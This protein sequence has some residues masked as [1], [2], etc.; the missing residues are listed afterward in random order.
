MISLRSRSSV[1]AEPVRLRFSSSG[2]TLIFGLT[3]A[4][5]LLM[6]FPGQILQRRLE[7]S[8]ASDSLTI[9]YLMAWLRA[10]PDDQH[11]RLQLALHQHETGQVFR[12]WTTLQ[13]V[14]ASPAL[15]EHDRYRAELLHLNLLEKL[16]WAE[17]ADSAIFMRR[18]KE[19]IEQL[20]I[21]SR[22]PRFDDRLEH[23]AA[24]A[25]AMGEIHLARN[26]YLRLITSDRPRN[27]NW[28]RQIAVLALAD[29]QP[30]MAGRILLLGLD[31][32]PTPEQRRILFLE[33]MR[34]FQA[35]NRLEEALNAARLRLGSLADDPVTLEA[36]ARLALAA[37][38]PDIAE[39]YVSLLLKQRIQTPG[40]QP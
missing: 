20:R 29:S 32:T 28:Y 3:V 21:L 17:R 14:L 23:F 30:A 10:K 22:S 36:L 5:I 2:Q 33:A 7:Q 35:A 38:R 6:M 25:Y 31:L 4:L 8:A 1:T 26:L 19:F 9:A 15:D 11:L 16:L 18:Q 39:Y 12:A 27:L 34:H 24:K 37:N 40:R 13:P